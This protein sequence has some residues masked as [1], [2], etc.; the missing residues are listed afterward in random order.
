[1]SQSNNYIAK[2]KKS[3]KY[4]VRN[5]KRKDDVECDRCTKPKRPHKSDTC[6][7]KD[8]ECRSCK[9]IGHMKGARRCKNTKIVQRISLSS[10]EDVEEDEERMKEEKNEDEGSR[11]YE[12]EANWNS[13]I[14][15]RDEQPASDITIKQVTSKKNIVK[16]RVGKTDTEMYADSGADVNVAPSTWYRKE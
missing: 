7:F 13:E 1:M 14:S 12:D 16:V 10:E 3:G 4:S 9:E 8:Q 6:Y 15:D 5:E 11:D 2:L